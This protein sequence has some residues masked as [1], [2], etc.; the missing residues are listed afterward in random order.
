MYIFATPCLIL[1]TYFKLLW[2]LILPSF[3]YP[4]SSTQRKEHGSPHC[5]FGKAMLRRTGSQLLNP[6]VRTS[7][8]HP[9]NY[10]TQSPM[11]CS[12]S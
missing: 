8:T 2:S 6:P 11:L 12:H 1:F 7:K 3:S 9:Q 5:L 4:S 10:G